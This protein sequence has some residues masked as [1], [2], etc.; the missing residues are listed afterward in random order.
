MIGKSYFQTLIKA[1]TG[2]ATI[3]VESCWCERTFSELPIVDTILYVTRMSCFANVDI[4]RTENW[5]INRYWRSDRRVGNVCADI[6]M[7]WTLDVLKLIVIL[8]RGGGYFSYYCIT[9]EWSVRTSLFFFF[10]GNTP[11]IW[12]TVSNTSGGG[13]PSIIH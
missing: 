7:T 3:P 9:C 13:W 2:S 10:F 5:I 1:L 4:Y 12:N 6:K 11:A 8:C